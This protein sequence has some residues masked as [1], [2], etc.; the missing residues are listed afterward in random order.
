METAVTTERTMTARYPWLTIWIAPRSTMREILDRDPKHLFL[1]L[2]M[3]GGFEKL[4]WA[5]FNT[6]FGDLS[7][8]AFI[9]VNAAIFGPPLAIARVFLQSAF[10]TWTGRLIGGKGSHAEVRSAIVWSG[11]PEI[12]TIIYWFLAVATF[13]SELFSSVTP[14]IDKSAYLTVQYFGLYAVIGIFTFW[15]IVL[16]LICLAEAQRFT[17]WKAFVNTVLAV[18]IVVLPVILI[19]L[20]RS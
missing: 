14:V 7:T 4:I 13:G 10:L 17:V 3:L 2:C 8:V 9:F 18:G 11:I 1:T 20:L 5:S 15:G 12:A 19:L 16:Y 6:H